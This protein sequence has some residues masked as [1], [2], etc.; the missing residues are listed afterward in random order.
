MRLVLRI[1][2][3]D[4]E[5]KTDVLL[6]GG[7]PIPTVDDY[8]TF[9]VHPGEWTTRLVVERHYLRYSPEEVLVE[10]A[11]SSLDDDEESP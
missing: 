7:A 11:V 2:D 9:E 4:S 10:V 5:K 1:M 8:V 3:Y 6:D